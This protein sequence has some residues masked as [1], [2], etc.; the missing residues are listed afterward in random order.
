[1]NL[2][3]LNTARTDVV[4]Q[5]IDDFRFPTREQLS[6]QTGYSDE[7]LY[8]AFF[9]MY[10]SSF[11]MLNHSKKHLPV[12]YN[13]VAT[14]PRY[15]YKETGF[16]FKPRAI[17]LAYPHDL[18][19]DL[20]QRLAGRD[21][22]YVLPAAYVVMD[23]VHNL[24]AEESGVDLREM[25]DVLTNKAGLV[26]SPVKKFFEPEDERPERL[27]VG[28]EDLA[29]KLD[30]VYGNLKI[31]QDIVRGIYKGMI[32]RWERTLN[33]LSDPTHEYLPKEER[34]YI[35]GV[36]GWMIDKTESRMKKGEILGSKAL[37][38]IASERIGDV[39][40]VI[41]SGD[42]VES[43]RNLVLPHQS[44]IITDIDK[45]LYVMLY[46][47]GLADIGK[48]YAAGMDE[49]PDVV[50]CVDARDTCTKFGPK[51]ENTINQ[52]RKH[53]RVIEVMAEVVDYRRKNH[54][55]HEILSKANR[56]LYMDLRDAVIREREDLEGASAEQ[57]QLNDDRDRLRYMENLMHGFGAKLGIEPR[58]PIGTA[59]GAI[60]KMM[61]GAN[62]F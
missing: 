54:L 36:I 53:R 9:V 24:L 55:K 47:K 48:G 46:L 52:F 4:T 6:Q 1:M 20:G 38:E 25:L 12:H 31:T 51:I 45:T 62:L 44:K 30:E 33:V 58:G 32:S 8:R 34:K 23:V 21:Q 56:F 18:P 26:F 2:L 28:R 37:E 40:R 29:A 17:V 16:E 59:V 27:E 10:A 57:T 15:R 35:Q 60:S 5:V 7:F 43:D 61:R 3:R 11:N 42:L 39:R 41:T 13:D 50:K 49:D 19:E 14:S 22:R